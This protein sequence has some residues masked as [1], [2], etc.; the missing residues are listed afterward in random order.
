MG[1]EDVSSLPTVETLSQRHHAMFVLFH[2]AQQSVLKCNK[3]RGN[4]AQAAWRR[5]PRLSG[6]AYTRT[7][8]SVGLCFGRRKL[9]T[10][11]HGNC[12]RV[13]GKPSPVHTSH[14]LLLTT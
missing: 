3:A 13:S 1:G 6:R 12:N 9:E 8:T 5:E 2:A 11:R 14:R 4:M 7:G 10:S